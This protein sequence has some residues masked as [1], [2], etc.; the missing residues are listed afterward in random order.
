MESSLT[1]INLENIIESADET[2][3]SAEVACGGGGCEV[4]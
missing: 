1:S 2:D 3:L 4:P